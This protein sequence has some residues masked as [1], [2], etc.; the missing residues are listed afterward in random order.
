LRRPLI[1]ETDAPVAEDADLARAADAAVFGSF[2]GQDQLCM[3]TRGSPCTGR[4]TPSSPS[5]W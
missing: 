4:R 2:A 5:G 1:H 3:I